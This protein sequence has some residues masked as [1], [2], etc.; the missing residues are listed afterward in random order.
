[1]ELIEFEKVG[2]LEA[3]NTDGLRTLNQDNENS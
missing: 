2:S 3:F 1:M